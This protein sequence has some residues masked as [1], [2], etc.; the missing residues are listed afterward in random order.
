MPDGPEYSPELARRDFDSC[1]AILVRKLPP[2]HP[3]IA[4]VKGLLSRST[5]AAGVAAA[6]ATKELALG[7]IGGK[8]DISNHSSV[9]SGAVEVDVAAV[10]VAAALSSTTTALAVAA[11]NVSP[12]VVEPLSF[13]PSTTSASASLASSSFPSSYSR[14]AKLPACDAPGCANTETPFHTS[15]LECNGCKRTAYCCKGC[16]SAHWKAGH[17]VECK[18]AAQQRGTFNIAVE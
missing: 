14:S 7:H 16:Q 11:R 2:G 1:Q 10:A 15:L 9:G 18:A 12:V 6:V 5:L 8:G 13:S 3:T 17:R 4:K